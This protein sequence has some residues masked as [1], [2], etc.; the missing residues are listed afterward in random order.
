[1]YLASRRIPLATP[2]NAFHIYR[3][4]WRDQDNVVRN[5]QQSAGK[6]IYP[7]LRLIRASVRQC[8][9][10]AVAAVAAAA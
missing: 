8:C 10:V 2:D 9:V 6:A 4:E 5:I 3:G 1:M 7:S